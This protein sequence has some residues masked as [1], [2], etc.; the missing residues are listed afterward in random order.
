GEPEDICISKPCKN[1]GT[2][3]KKRGRNYKCHCVEGY[4]GN[5]CGDI[6]WCKDNDKNICGDN[7][8]C[9]YDQV[10]RSG[11]CFCEKDFYFDAKNKKC[12]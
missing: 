10:I 8:T 6:T 4:S 3:E 7:V 9:K 11:Y 12:Q 1:G 5:N 2:C